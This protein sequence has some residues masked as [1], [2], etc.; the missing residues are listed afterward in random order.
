MMKNDWKSNPLIADFLMPLVVLMFYCVSYMFLSSWLLLEGVNYIFVSK[1][2]KYLVLLFVIVGLIT[3]IFAK[4]RINL[5]LEIFH[6]D[7]GFTISNLLLLFLPLTPVVQYIIN[8]QD[9]LSP[10]DSIIVF[11]FF[12]LVSGI[13]ILVIPWLFR[14]FGST[15]ILLAV[16]LAFTTTITNMAL[17][18]QA[19]HWFGKGSLRYQLPVMGVVFLLAYL[20]YSGKRKL[21]LYAIITVFFLSNSVMQL[22]QIIRQAN[23]PSFD[24]AENKLLSIVGNRVPSRTPNIYLLVYDSYV[25]NETML[26]YGF[27]NSDQEDYLQ[28]QG[29]TLYPHTYSVG[30]NSIDSMSDVFNV[31][32][33]PYGNER[34]GVSGD[35]VVQNLFSSLGYDTYGVFTSDYF[36]QGIGSSYDHTIPEFQSPPYRHLITAILMGEFRF[37]LGFGK[38]NHT[39]FEHDK[40]DSF[41]EISR[42]KGFIYTHTDLPSH[43]QNSG[44]CL[45][46][47]NEIYFSRFEKANSEMRQDIQTIISNDPGAIVIVA[48]DHGPY[49]TKN[50][51]ILSGHYETSEISRLDIQDRF[52]TFLAIRWPTEEYDMYDE[53]TVLQ[54]I[55]PAI[56][57]YLYGDAGILESKIEPVITYSYIISAASVNNGVIVGGIDNGEPLFLSGE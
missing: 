24:L 20:L 30:F 28:E 56:F 38:L 41:L 37:D 55:F 8:N 49:L 57:A 2:W 18:S 4:M 54:D 39:Q 9:I 43:S 27:D 26:A 22:S 14:S 29:F 44:A 48:G 40:L 11:I 23:E 12:L 34:R 15:R 42:S 53:I 21:A 35:G 31:S 5:K 47:E 46:D 45:P 17:I 33:D 51:D 10:K 1:L 3:I 52:G 6:S 7:E 25:A 36:F 16:G 32:N 13:L 50:C 19:H